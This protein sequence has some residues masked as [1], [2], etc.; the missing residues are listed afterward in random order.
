MVPNIGAA[1]SLGAT[2]ALWFDMIP[3][4]A[5]SRARRA[6]ALLI[7]IHFAWLLTGC[8]SSYRYSCTW[9]KILLPF[10]LSINPV[11]SPYM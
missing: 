8:G 2:R 6:H 7:L 9:L 3:P 4:Q 5:Q 11:I 10:K 1:I